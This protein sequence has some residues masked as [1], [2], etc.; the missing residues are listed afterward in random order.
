MRPIFAIETSRFVKGAFRCEISFSDP[1]LFGFSRV[2]GGGSW[3]R[4]LGDRMGAE[5]DV[6][7]SGRRL[8]VEC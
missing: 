3:Q 7:N 8:G 5:E 6:G 4:E 2:A 1:V